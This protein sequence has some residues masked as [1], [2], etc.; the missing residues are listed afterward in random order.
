MDLRNVLLSEADKEALQKIKERRRK[1]AL[2]AYVIFFFSVIS[3]FV[4]GWVIS[5]LEK[6]HFL[7]QYGIYVA[8]SLAALVAIP[9]FIAFNVFICKRLERKE[10][11]PILD[12][13]GINRAD[14]V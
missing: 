9:S 3:L 14:N 6:N 12:K 10:A 7:V 13:Y 8:L 4:F 11:Q 2:I 1:K 5:T